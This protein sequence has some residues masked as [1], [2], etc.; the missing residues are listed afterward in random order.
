MNNAMLDAK[1]RY[2]NVCS[3]L[4]IVV[5]IIKRSNPLAINPVPFFFFKLSFSIF[6]VFNCISLKNQKMLH[7]KFSPFP[8]VFSKQRIESHTNT[9][10]RIE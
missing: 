2:F 10:K 9:K 8:F 4:G 5:E 7:S 1:P 3:S 6:S